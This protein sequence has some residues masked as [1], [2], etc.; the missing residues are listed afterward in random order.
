MLEGKYCHLWQSKK[1]NK[2]AKG[3]KPHSNII[4]GFTLVEL[5]VVVLVIAIVAAAGG[6]A[7]NQQLPGYR[8]RGDVR[9][10]TSSLMMARM[11][12]T[13]TGLVYAIEFDLDKSPQ[14]YCLRRGNTNDVLPST[15]WTKEPYTRQLSS[16]VNIERVVDNGATSLSGNVMIIYK[17]NGSYNS[18]SQG[19]IRLRLGT[20]NDGDRILLTPTTG[21]LESKK[22]WS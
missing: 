7:L 3:L 16:G 20:L 22:G 1:S 11:K 10:L 19:L 13:S 6:I 12:A 17:P 8:L 2:S 21:R 4:T 14:E 15:V 9:T 18:N 5:M